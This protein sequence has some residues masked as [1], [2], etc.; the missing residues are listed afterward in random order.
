[1]RLANG[2]TGKHAAS[3]TLREFAGDGRKIGTLSNAL[4]KSKRAMLPPTWR[5]TIASK[6]PARSATCSMS[7]LRT[8]L[9]PRQSSTIDCKARTGNEFRVVAGEK[10]RRPGNILGRTDIAWVERLE[11]RFYVRVFSQHQRIDCPG[12]NRVCANTTGAALYGCGSRQRQHRCFRGRVG[13]H[14]G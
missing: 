1:M 14:I 8:A 4:F 5:E 12:Q 13:R 10:K 7:A 11:P 9:Q 3:R 6:F 2:T